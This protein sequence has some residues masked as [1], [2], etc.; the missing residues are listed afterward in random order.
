MEDNR[1]SSLV[2][3]I[4]DRDGCVVDNGCLIPGWNLGPPVIKSYMHSYPTNYGDP[5]TPSDRDSRYSGLRIDIPMGRVTSVRFSL[6]VLNGLYV[7]VLIG[8]LVFFIKPVRVDVRFGTGVGAVFAAIASKYVI[9]SSLPEDGQ[10]ML[11]DEL[12]ALGTAI[13]FLCSWNPLS[14]TIWLKRTIIWPQ[15]DWIGLLSY[16]L[17]GRTSPQTFG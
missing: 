13:I 4:V 10:L 9:A 17:P 7:S 5:E 1:E 8:L 15:S 6:K 2:R 11:V 14:P 12:Y 3:D 16:C